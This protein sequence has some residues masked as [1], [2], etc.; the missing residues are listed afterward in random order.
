MVWVEGYLRKDGT[1]VQGHW[2]KQSI[3][4]RTESNQTNSKQIR[5]E[6][7]IKS[8]NA[9]QVL[10]T[11]PSTSIGG[12]VSVRGYYRKDGT[13]VRPYTRSYPKKSYRFS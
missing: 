7:L 12:K 2:R 9:R 1:Y 5:A 4:R 8:Y 11:A 10:S 13:Y 6:L 3:V